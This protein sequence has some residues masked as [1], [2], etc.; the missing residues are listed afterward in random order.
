MFYKP[1]I[2]EKIIEY[3]DKH[4]K[5]NYLDTKAGLTLE[6]T[7]ADAELLT[8]ASQRTVAAAENGLLQDV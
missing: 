2:E 8:A 7:I 1:I 4:V 6:L 3:L 5:H